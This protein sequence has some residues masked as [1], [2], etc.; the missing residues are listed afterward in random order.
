MSLY[1]S[2][3]KLT[4]QATSVKNGIVHSSCPLNLEMTVD[5]R[6]LKLGST[7]CNDI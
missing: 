3:S 2:T 7:V 1:E 4:K 6:M 5:N